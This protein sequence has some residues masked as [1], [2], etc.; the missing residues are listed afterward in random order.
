MQLNLKWQTSFYNDIFISVKKA[1]HK[2][3]LLVHPDRVE[4]DKKLEATE[5]FKVLGK[6]HSILSDKNKRS[7]YDESGEFDEE[8]DALFNWL[9]YWRSLFKKI[10]VADIQ[11]YEQ[12]Y[13]GSETEKNDVKRAYL[14][15]NGNMDHILET[16]PFANCDNEPRYMEIIK[17]MIEKGEVPEYKSFTEEPEKKKEKRKKKWEK[18][19]QEAAS[20]DGK[21]NGILL[22]SVLLTTY[23]TYI[24]EAELNKAIQESQARREKKMSNFFSELEAKYGGKNKTQNKRKSI[25]STSGDTPPAKRTRSKK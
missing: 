7:I 12:E 16:V 5:K 8:S 6:I 9:E 4:E 10:T 20:I 25:K 11:K 1:Y 19:K 2:V 15:R 13:I 18:E 21:N 24:T 3:S 17:E 22:F 23:V 14:A